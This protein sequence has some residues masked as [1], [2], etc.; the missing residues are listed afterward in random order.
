MRAAFIQTLRELAAED[1]RIVLLTGDLGYLALEPFAEQFPER[2]FNV[3]V[4]EQN[5]VGLA[6]GLAE[7]GFHPYIYSIVPFVTL[8]P[9]EF[10]RNGP[11]H[12]R[13]PVRI[14]GVGGGFEY[15]TN[16]I[17]HYGLEDIGVMRIQP[18]ISV[19]APADSLQART[20]FQK[21]KDTPGPVYFRIGKDNKTEVPGLD[22][23]FSLD[24]IPLI[25]EGKDLLLL[26]M[27]SISSSVAE[28]GTRLQSQGIS[29]TI[30]V[31][32]ALAPVPLAALLGLLKQ[33]PAVMTIEA[34][35]QNG[36]IGSLVAEI[37]AE[38][39]VP[40]RLKRCG[41]N[42]QPDG[43][44]GNQEFMHSQHHLSIDDLVQSSMNLLKKF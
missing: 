37:I 44:T 38:E 24:E 39:G 23:R 11:I 18:G 42:R 2:F 34:H 13:L 21:M 40:C 14:V 36:G 31:I 4:A 6:T 1:P 35:F 30:G 26:T 22:G 16:G 9:Y 7:A 8:R 10:I 25:R 17:S 41:V 12:H 32:A 28:V 15:A 3:G 20:C 43:K 27:G 33:F 29:T 5:M 19:V